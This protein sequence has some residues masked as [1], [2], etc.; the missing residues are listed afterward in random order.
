M[1]QKYMYKNFTACPHCAAKGRKRLVQPATAHRSPLVSRSDAKTFHLFLEESYVRPNSSHTGS[2]VVALF[3]FDLDPAG[4]KGESSLL[5]LPITSSA[6]GGGIS[7]IEKAAD[8]LAGTLAR[9]K[10]LPRVG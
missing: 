2:E 1:I 5:V 10:S 3:R 8:D 9:G 6:A 4:A 7:E